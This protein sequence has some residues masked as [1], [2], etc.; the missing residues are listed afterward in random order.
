MRAMMLTGLSQIEI[1]EASTPEITHDRGVLI[2]MGAVGVCGSDTHYY[3]HGRIGS[4]IV[5]FPFTV[6]HEGAGTIE[7][8][9]PGVTKTP[10][11]MAAFENKELYDR[12]VSLVPM[13]RLGETDNIIGA[14]I[15]LASD[16]SNYVTGQTLYI[17]GGRMSD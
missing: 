3:L 7:A 2:R 4:Q 11:T 15:Y 16:A 9:G 10:M 6:G 5:K 12:Q 1:H 17:E 14:V 8:I 13:G